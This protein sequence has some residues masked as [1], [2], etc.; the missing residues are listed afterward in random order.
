MID[1]KPAFV[2]KTKDMNP[3]ENHGTSAG[4]N[5]VFINVCKSN[6]IANFSKKVKLDENGNEQE[7]INIPLSLGLPHPV[8]DKSG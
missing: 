7:G 8:V 5:K 4:S 2:I 1:V 3:M 6:E